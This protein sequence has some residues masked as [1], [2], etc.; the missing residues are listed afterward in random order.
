MTPHPEFRSGRTA[1]VIGV[2][3]LLVALLWISYHEHD[4][5]RAVLLSAPLVAGVACELARLRAARIVNVGY[6]TF[7]FVALTLAVVLAAL[8]VFGFGEAE[9]AG[10]AWLLIGVPSGV[11]ALLLNWLYRVTSERVVAGGSA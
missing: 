11:F 1:L 5:R 7:L 3:G 10:A 4:L 2:N 6:F 8:K 9:H